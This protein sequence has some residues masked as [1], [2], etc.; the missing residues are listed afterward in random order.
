MDV[1]AGNK[2][3]K[4]IQDFGSFPIER[5][6]SLFYSSCVR[7]DERLASEAD[8]QAE[9]RHY[10]G[11]GAERLGATSQPPLERYIY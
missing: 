2:F 6:Q 7:R 10:K 1:I 4:N 9:S 3:T 5:Y 8:L 11:G